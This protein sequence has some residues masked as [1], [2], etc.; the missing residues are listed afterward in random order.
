[1]SVSELPQQHCGG[2]RF[3][4]FTGVIPLGRGTTHV[5]NVWPRL[6]FVFFLALFEKVEGNS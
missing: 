6:G 4:L 2:Q 3:A 5:N 1:M